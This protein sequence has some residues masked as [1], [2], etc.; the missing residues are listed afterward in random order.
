MEETHWIVQWVDDGCFQGHCNLVSPRFPL[1]WTGSK[2]VTSV[3]H[4]AGLLHFPLCHYSSPFLTLLSDLALCRLS[5]L[6]T[7]I[8]CEQKGYLASLERVFWPLS[9][10]LMIIHQE[11][12]PPHGVGIKAR[13]PLSSGKSN[14]IQEAEMDW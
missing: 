7:A 6:S 14:V 10:T 2:T 13:S 3:L 4:V 9:P 5:G 12:R 11:D 8:L 1:S